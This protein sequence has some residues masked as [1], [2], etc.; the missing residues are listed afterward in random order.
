MG[1]HQD[2]SY[3]ILELKGNRLVTGTARTTGP[4]TAPRAM[5]AKTDMATAQDLS[6]DTTL[7]S[8]VEEDDDDL[9]EIEQKGVQSVG[10]SVEP[11]GVVTPELPDLEPDMENDGTASEHMTAMP[12][13]EP[14]ATAMP[15][16]QSQE[17]EL[18]D[19]EPPEYESPEQKSALPRQMQVQMQGQRS[20][21][22]KPAK[23][24]R[25]EP[26][27]KVDKP[28]EERR[29][30]RASTRNTTTHYQMSDLYKPKPMKEGTEVQT[31]YKW[32]T[33]EVHKALINGDLELTWPGHSEAGVRT[34]EASDMGKLAW[35]PEEKQ[36]RYDYDGNKVA[37]V[38]QAKLVYALHAVE[39]SKELFVKGKFLGFKISDLVGNVRAAAVNSALPQPD[40]RLGW[41]HPFQELVKPAKEKELT[42]LCEKGTF[43]EPIDLP[44]GHKRIPVM[45]VNG[46]K[47]DDKGMYEKMKSQ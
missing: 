16:I 33:A 46:A 15:T 35:R 4:M 45:F 3:S 19:S 32:G 13:L 5:E 41:D 14:L 39:V 8:V 11:G 21:Q 25:K 22:A 12:D 18:P 24:P 23:E 31:N 40:H 2:W 27:A 38:E 6:R 47:H 28:I 30:T 44:N 42:G 17:D 1:H 36:E 37:D 34:I 26:E 7:T 29:A 43:G 10:D 9:I 20:R